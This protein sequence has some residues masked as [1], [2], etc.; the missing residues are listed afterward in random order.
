LGV[1]DEQA[2]VGADQD[3]V[4][5]GARADHYHAPDPSHAESAGPQVAGDVEEAGPGVLRPPDIGGVDDV[6]RP[7][8]TRLERDCDWLTTAP[9]GGCIEV[10]DGPPDKQLAAGVADV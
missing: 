1:G 6:C 3:G 7:P 10:P 9:G 5:Q 8:V 2:D 4:G